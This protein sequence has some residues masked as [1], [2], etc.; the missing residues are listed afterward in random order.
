MVGVACGARAYV[1]VGV[2][3]PSELR[4]TFGPQSPEISLM[5][6]KCWQEGAQYFCARI[7]DDDEVDAKTG[8]EVL[9]AKVVD[10]DGEELQAS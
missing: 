3:G 6:S 10:V 2:E 7:C 5:A 9:E 8:V 1:G 4:T